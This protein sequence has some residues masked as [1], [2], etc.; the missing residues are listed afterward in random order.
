MV[1][2]QKQEN[3]LI[4]AIKIPKNNPAKIPPARTNF[5][6]NAGFTFIFTSFTSGEVSLFKSL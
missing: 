6:F 4:N 1:V 2:L 5:L 3:S